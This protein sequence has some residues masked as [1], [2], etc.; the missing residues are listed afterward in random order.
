MHI[1]RRPE[2][3]TR[4]LLRAGIIAA[5]AFGTVGC[6]G[7][8]KVT[9]PGS[10]QEGQLDDPALETFLVNGAVGEFQFAY[11]SYA[12]ISG[13][14]A[15]EGFLDHPNVD[16][17]E[18]ALHNFNDINGANE[19]VYGSLQQARQSADDATTR[20][21]KMLGAKAGASLSVARALIYGGYAYVLLGEGFC[22]SPVNL[23]APLPS[24]ELLT[25]AVAHFDEGIAVATAALTDTTGTTAT[26][27]QDLISL[28]RVGAARASLKKGDLAKARAYASAV[29]ETY[30]RWA[31]YSANS[32]RENNAVQIAVRQGQPWLAMQPA[33]RGLNDARVPQPATTR[34]SLMGNPIFPPLKPSMYSGWTGKLPGQPIDV[35]SSIRFASG[36]EAHYIIVEAD[37]PGAAMLTFVNG[38]RASAGKPPVNLEGPGLVAEFRT[39]RALDFY[40]TGQRLGDLRRYADAGT[41]LFP[42]GK[43]PTL[44]DS[45]GTM[46]C[47]IVPLSEKSSNP[48]Y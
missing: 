30:E 2:G 32:A 24:R 38:R 31:Y 15:D 8:L 27:A 23:S 7:L 13:V 43:Y 9:N 46:H 47:F 45:Y 3:A 26:D 1:C 11:T 5:I 10:L 37:G 25:R 28:A 4:T 16:L 35:A 48:N 44:R 34:P 19:A 17:R 20:V 14:L 21:K 40:L 22:E 42:T 12:F 6:D 29:P 41:D 36:L 33:Y 18:F 39:Q